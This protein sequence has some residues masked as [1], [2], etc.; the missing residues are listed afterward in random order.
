MTARKGTKGVG[1]IVF[2]T[3][4][5]MTTLGTAVQELI[6]NAADFTRFASNVNEGTTYEGTTIILNSDIDL[7]GQ[8]PSDFPIGKDA[9][10]TFQGIFDGEGHII[11]NLKLEAASNYIGLF[12]AV[13]NG[14]TIRNLV[15]DSSCSFT[16]THSE[17]S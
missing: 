7:S 11:K 5:T 10:K 13:K 15:I 9:E 6:N 1:L 8:Q 16:N 14:A 12:G 4:A 3:L 17:N 2:T